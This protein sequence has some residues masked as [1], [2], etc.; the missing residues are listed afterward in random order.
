MEVVMSEDRHLWRLKMDRRLLS[1]QD[2][3]LDFQEKNLNLARNLW[4][5][6]KV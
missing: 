6:F 5:K 3:K 1:V 2:I 4:I